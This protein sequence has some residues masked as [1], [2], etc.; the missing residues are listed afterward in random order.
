MA[1]QETKVIIC[2]NIVEDIKPFIKGYNSNNIFI[3]TD[4]NTLKHCAGFIKQVEGLSKAKM[5]T[6]K[7]GDDHKSIEA[8]ADVWGFLTENG[9]DR[10]A[11]LINLGGGMVTDL[12]GF[13]AS[14]FK[15]GIDFINIPTTLLSVVD[16]AVGGKTG[17]N[18]HQYKNEIGVIQ[19]ADAVLVDT[20]FLK[21]MD[22]D[23]FLSGFG[24]MIKHGLIS[25]E[26]HWNEVSH[27]NLDSPDLAIL[28]S[29]VRDSIN[30]KSE[31]VKIDP[32]EKGIR[33]SLNLGHTIGHAFESF[34][35]SQE[36]S[37]LHGFAVA[38]GLVVELYLSHKKL[39]F[40]MSLLE[41]VEALVTK[42]YGQF[43]FSASD[44]ETLFAYMK[45]DKKNKDGRINFSLMKNI[46]EVEVDV[47]CTKEEVFASLDYY[48]RSTRSAL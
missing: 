19:H 6:I 2:N 17:I 12:G 38:W 15:R 29:L 36:R 8:M 47:N 39:N 27:F 10:H 28:K 18:F 44:Y 5:I 46:G 14:T 41:D 34:A 48:R 35:M 1:S 16:A 9:A 7:A 21:T 25:N 45:H 26:K 31:V 11:L 43:L 3:L 33:K 13:A 24:E 42:H 32:L 4:Q 40:P 22:H 37:V 30:V 20:I 23:N